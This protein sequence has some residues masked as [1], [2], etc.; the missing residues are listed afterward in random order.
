MESSSDGRYRVVARRRM[1]A[2]REIV[3]E[4]WIDPKGIQE[5]MCPGDVVSAEATLDVRVGG[6]F[7]LVMKSKDKD[8][9]H[10]GTYQVVEW[11][12]KLVFTWAGVE[13][14]EDI[15]LVT[16]E[17][18][19]YGDESELVLTH[20][21]FLKIDAAE[22]YENGWGTIAD[23]FASFLS[24]RVLTVARDKVDASRWHTFP[25]KKHGKQ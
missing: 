6:S 16:V 2:P 12:S 13:N 11:P 10:I 23:K 22:R 14:P 25:E 7:R 20:E 18:F 24:R 5:W 8:H 19:P 9:V 3:F 4:A 1:P 15:T 21:R 17:L